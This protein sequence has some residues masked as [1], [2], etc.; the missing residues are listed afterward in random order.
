MIPTAELAGADPLASDAP[1]I[2]YL[3][4][5]SPYAFVALG[6]TLELEARLGI[7]IDWRPLTLDIG[8]FAGEARTDGHGKV[9]ENRRSPRQW[10]SVKYAYSDARRYAKLRGLTLRGTTKIWD[11]SLAGIALLWAREHPERFG[12]WAQ[13]VYEPFWRRDLDI[14]DPAVIR[15]TL[16]AAGFDVDGFD[17]FV[18]GDGRRIHDAL[19][20]GLH[21]AGLF[22]VPTYV[23]EG[24]PW[25]GREH[26]PTVAWLLGGRRGPAPDI[27]YRRLP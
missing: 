10:A 25:F 23:V 4:F 15:A 7:T 16:V 17:A 9:L 2:V 5:K 26:L 18:A 11:S 12:R 21:P 24:R 19:Q 6:P 13:A 20:A 1:L 22:G 27:A 14:E 3:D 8:S